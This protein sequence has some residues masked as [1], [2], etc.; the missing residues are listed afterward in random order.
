MQMRSDLST[1]LKELSSSDGYHLGQKEMQWFIATYMD[2]ATPSDARNSDRAP[3]Y[4]LL[5][6]KVCLNADWL[7]LLPVGEAY[8]SHQSCKVMRELNL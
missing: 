2:F 7:L 8:H 1:A 5:L 6:K 4:D 3:R